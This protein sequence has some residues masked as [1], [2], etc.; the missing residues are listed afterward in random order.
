MSLETGMRK[1]WLW[2]GL[3]VAGLCGAGCIEQSPDVP[4][5]EDVK[6]AKEN[7]LS[8]PPATIKF[9]VNGELEGKVTYLGMD[10]DTD[11]VSP[12]KPFQL[13]HYWKVNEP[14]GADWRVFVHLESPGSARNH[15]NADHVPIGGKYP[16]AVWKKGDIIRDIHRVSVPAT[17]TAPAV[18]IYTGLWKGKVRL[19]T[20]A[21][22][23]DADNRVKVA[24][25]P[26]EV[27]AAAPVVARRIVATKV[28]EG[29]IKLD[30]KLD[31]PAWATARSTGPFVRT[32]D[33]TPA[34]SKAEAKVLWDDKFLYVAFA[35]EDKDVWT[36]LGSRDDKL[37]TQ[38]AV[39]VFI[40]ADG[41]KATY[42]ELQTNPKGAIFD[43]WLPK[44][45]ENH[46]DFDAGMKV[47]VN[48]DGTVDKRDDTDKGWTVEMQIPLVAARGPEATMKNVPPTVGTIW[49][50]NFF[51]MDMPAGKPQQGTAWSPPLVGD[52]HALD[53]FAE[54]AFG[55]DKGMLPPPTPA[56]PV[57]ATAPGALQAPPPNAPPLAAPK[58]AMRGSAG[59]KSG[60]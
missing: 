58:P 22:P 10:V 21:G 35:L 2:Q 47:A 9:P 36:T 20:T 27:T 37:W 16:V 41:D 46:N 45:R 48:V 32:M 39:E 60:K 44:Y 1:A 25:L 42:V 28:K 3:V 6:V 12:G 13:T 23:H 7:L 30:G 24:V 50:V 34:E 14:V 4:S 26:V 5:E 19:K 17:W 55:D 15:L 31:E 52:F 40:D 57:P 33:G 59:H 18:E 54:L 29:T 11:K 8:A 53:K 56:T 51:R 43:S 38:E 49:K